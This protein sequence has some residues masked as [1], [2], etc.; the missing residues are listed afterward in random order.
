LEWQNL[1][2][3]LKSVDGV[4]DQLMLATKFLSRLCSQAGHEEESRAVKQH[5]FTI[6]LISI[7][8]EDA[9][10]FLRLL[11]EHL[12]VEADGLTDFFDHAK[13]NALEFYKNQSI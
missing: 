4:E 11:P 2:Q 13:L 7:C 12:S 6:K 10:S 9:N 3:Y 5:W 8:S 1:I